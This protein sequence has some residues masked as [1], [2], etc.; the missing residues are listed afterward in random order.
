[1]E[2]VEDSVDPSDNTET[3]RDSKQ[4][5]SSRQN[6]YD[7]IQIPSSRQNSNEN[8]QNPPIARNGY[9]SLS[10]DSSSSSLNGAIIDNG[11]N[12]KPLKLPEIDPTGTLI[13]QGLNNQRPPSN[14]QRPG[15]SNSSVKTPINMLRNSLGDNKMDNSQPNSRMEIMS[16]DGEFMSPRPPSGEKRET[17]S[18]NKS[19]TVTPASRPVT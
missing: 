17:G 11:R 12:S 15:S 3:G 10:R 18:A 5:T 1:M 19:R 13:T 7:E 8:F 6:Q 2:K 14:N 16:F 9:K 4:N